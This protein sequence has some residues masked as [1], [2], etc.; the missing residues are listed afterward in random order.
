VDNLL[1]VPIPAG[2]SVSRGDIVLCDWESG[3]G[4]QRAIVVDATDPLSPKVRYL[5]LPFDHPSGYAEQEDKLSQGTFRQVGKAGEPGSTAVCQQGA[6]RTRQ[7]VIRSFA[8]NL[9]GYSF[10]RRISLWQRDS[11][12]LLDPQQ[13]RR[14]G[15]KVLVPVLGRYNPARLLEV[16][17]L[18]G[19][20]RAV[21]GAQGEKRE[22]TFAL[23]DIADN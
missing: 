14:R 3:A 8:D 13:K 19:T 15:E 20:A 21:H 23:V 4:M 12:Q 7:V 16:D 22:D 1:I 17:S 2:Q 18:A 6:K 10:S 11:C 5:D 9:V